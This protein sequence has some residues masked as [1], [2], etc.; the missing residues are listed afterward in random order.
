MKKAV[1]DFKEQTDPEDRLL[2]TE[3]DQY[4]HVDYLQ[5]T[6][7]YG[8][9]YIYRNYN[10]SQD[11]KPEFPVTI[12]DI[13]TKTYFKTSSRLEVDFMNFIKKGKARFY[14]KDLDL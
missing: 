3:T 4:V 11:L 6:R 14:P 5:Y 2:I 13:A 1:R 9:L 7:H 10:P 8:E 12:F